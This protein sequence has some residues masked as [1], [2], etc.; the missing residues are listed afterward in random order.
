[1][2]NIFVTTIIRKSTISNAPPVVREVRIAFIRRRRSGALALSDINHRFDFSI[3]A[4]VARPEA[5]RHRPDSTLSITAR[6][7]LAA[8]AV[9]ARVGSQFF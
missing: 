1:M 3:H 4:K 9:P 8:K 2:T 7:P 6:D 5:I